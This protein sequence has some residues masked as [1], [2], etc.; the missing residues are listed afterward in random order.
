MLEQVKQHL[1]ALGAS[2]WDEYRAVLAPDAIYQEMAT[3]LRANGAD[4]YVEAIQGW[5]R[6]FP[7]LKANVLHAF[8]GPNEVLL[9]VEWTGTHR[10][11]LEGP[12]GV[13]PATGKQG[14]VRAA[15]IFTVADE[16]I[17]ACRHYFDLLTMLRQ[18]GVALPMGAPAAKP[19]A[20]GEARTRH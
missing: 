13:I 20:K 1:D 9:E 11:A 18:L 17:V 19:E 15:I 7:D 12:L 5:K 16:R 3:G 6:A 10:G 14:I 2:K 4:A 8:A